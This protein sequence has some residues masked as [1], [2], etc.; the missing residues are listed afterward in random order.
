M[1]FGLFLYF[2]QYA[3]YG[4]PAGQP[5][6]TPWAFGA[7]LHFSLDGLS[8]LFALLITGIGTLVYAY[9]A[10]YMKKYPGVGRLYGW[11]S[12]FMAAMLGLVLAANAIT[13]F[14][15]WEL[16]SIA[17]FFLIGFKTH[18][19]ASR[20]SALT[21]LAITGSGGLALLA[22]M[23]LLGQETG[24]Y[25]L[26]DMVAAAP[27]LK[28][29][30]M[31][32]VAVWLLF[33]AAF[34]KSAQFPF[35]FW[36][37]G[38]MKAPTPVSTYL[39]SATMVKAGVYLLLRMGPA[40]GGTDLWHHVLTGVGGITMAYAAVHSLMRTDL[41]AILAYTT[42][43]ALG[44]LTFLAGLG[45]EHALRAAVVF[46]LV[47]ALYKA[48]LFLVAG[49]IDLSTGTRQVTELAGLWRHMPWLGAASALAVLS[50]AGLPLTLG[51]IG[52][53]LIYE[54]TL[55]YGAGGG[56]LTALVLSVN[57]LVAMAGA[58]AGVHPFR[59]R[60]GVGL[61]PNGVVPAGPALWVPAAV[62]SL[63]TLVFGMVPG[64]VDGALVQPALE[65]VYPGA[66]VA[67]LALWHGFNT[68]LYLSMATL[69]AALLLYLSVNGYA[70]LGRIPGALAPIAPA[71]LI[72]RLAKAFESLALLWNRSFQNGYLRYYILI[73]MSTVLALAAAV[74]LPGFVWTTDPAILNEV[75][76][77]EWVLVALILMGVAM[78][79]GT[80]S[81][82]TT[83]ASLG[84]VGYSISL[85]FVFYGAPDLAMTQFTIDTLTVILFVLVLYKLP[86]YLKL[87]RTR[88]KVRD[89]ILS[90]LFGSFMA[91]LVLD[92]LSTNRPD[93]STFYAE[94]AYLL[95]KG[96][97]VVN[98][99]LVDFRGF[100]TL[101]EIT[102]LAVAAIGVYGLLKLRV[103]R[104]EN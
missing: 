39:H 89:G 71:A 8:L 9:T 74:H 38:A 83:V 95:A 102:V 35:H 82:L 2:V 58:V 13:L 20:K 96:K 79:L 3:V 32:P 87:T 68:V 29:G 103:K 33:A 42:I 18:D 69:G 54:A 14:I 6:A 62:L 16:T 65:A 57:V 37:P 97:N 25:T 21:A 94:Q 78:A 27:A 92:V 72:T 85:L 17:S 34:T 22:S 49:T 59:S 15:F 50:G 46:L 10:A 47:H 90:A 44:M 7:S 45:T 98:V 23:L 86:R 48:A 51:F 1:P 76:G 93:V 41:K 36:L 100:D 26:S 40:V 104:Y 84:V 56:A 31:Y 30:A 80:R 43:A 4:L 52:K 75:T 60:R 11:L 70:V 19:E 12:V 77:Y 5:A 88:S 63:L 61:S 67:H 81:R 64:L 91:A 66:Q 101:V 24:S 55:H 99:I 73:I 28:T 53:D